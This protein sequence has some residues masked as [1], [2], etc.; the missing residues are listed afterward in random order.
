MNVAPGS[1]ENINVNNSV[2]THFADIG[3]SIGLMHII[4]DVMIP[5]H[6]IGGSP[7]E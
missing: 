3:T 6:L 7:A 5:D 4:E 2:T 1:G